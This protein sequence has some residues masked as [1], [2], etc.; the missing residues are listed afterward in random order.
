MASEFAKVR[1]KM[2]TG[3]ADLHKEIGQYFRHTILAVVGMM[4]VFAT[5]VIAFMRYGPMG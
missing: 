4:V 3:L 5:G 2:A 1:G